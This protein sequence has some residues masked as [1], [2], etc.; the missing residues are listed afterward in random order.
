[1]VS[2]SRSACPTSW[3]Q[4]A[5]DQAKTILK[6]TDQPHSASV[7]P[8]HTKTS[9]YS[10][11]SPFPAELLLNQAITAPGSSK[12]IRHL[13][14]SLEDS[15][16]SYQPGDALG[17]WP[18]QSELLIAEILQL[19]NIDGEQAVTQDETQRPLKEWLA[20]HRELTQLTRPFL[21]AH[22]ERSQSAELLALLQPDQAEAFRALVSTQQLADVLRKYPATWEANALVKA[23][24]P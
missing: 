5:L 14:F 13:E 11:E 2:I 4:K 19:L 15:Q 23:L 16:L 12:D 7:T 8:L 17:V 3:T 6:Q 9:R 22:A 20:E 24:R 1:M 10:R 21:Q 18:V